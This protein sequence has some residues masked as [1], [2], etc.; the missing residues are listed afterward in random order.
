[1]SADSR[2]EAS[3]KIN[4]IYDGV[5]KSIIAELETGR[6][7]WVQPWKTTRRTR[8]GLLP[9]NL[10]TGRTYSGINIPI[11]WQA[12]KNGGYTDHAWMTFQQALALKA[13]VR[14]GEKGTHIVFTKKITAKDDE[15]ERQ[16]AILRGYTVFNI[17]QIDG[18]PSRIAT[19]E[20]DVQPSDNDI[21]RFIKAT[22]ADIRHG[23]SRACFV[24]SLDI[25]QM[26]P[27]STFRT[28]EGYFATALHELGH[29]SGHETRLN[30]N[31]K[32]R[33]GS[34]AYAAE[35]LIAELT[36]AFLCAHLSVNGELR[37]AAYIKTWIRLLKEDSRAIFTAASKASQAADFL[38]SF[39]DGPH[40]SE[41]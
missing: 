33:F 23:G 5:T 2:T 35:E 9:A 39:S 27:Y 25:I 11:L 4:D 21:L 41:E 16:V 24:P 7:V 20:D 32:N 34:Q 36:S 26:P 18:L 8:L 3:L 10:A 1:M 29:W 19:L 30:R 14:K 15:E 40:L 12:A 37:H 13:T 17:A 22:N 38:R 28:S 6:P 31:L